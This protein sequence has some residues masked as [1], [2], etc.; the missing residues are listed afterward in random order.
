MINWCMSTTAMENVTI[1]I[2]YISYY[3]DGDEEIIEFN[4]ND[5]IEQSN[6]IENE[7]EEEMVEY[8]E[9]LLTEKKDPIPITIKSSVN[10]TT[11]VVIKNKIS[12][13]TRKKTKTYNLRHYN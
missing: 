10:K 12:T 4:L 3:S 13:N 2:T 6:I 9:P 8:I 1:N 5:T 7:I 11:N